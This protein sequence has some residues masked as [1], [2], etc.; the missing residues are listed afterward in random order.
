[1][2]AEVGLDIN[3]KG[4]MKRAPKDFEDE[5]DDDVGPVEEN[6]ESRGR[7]GA[8]TN[9]PTAG[10]KGGMAI[11]QTGAQRKRRSTCKYTNFANTFY[12]QKKE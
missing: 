2:S 6:F 8:K 3:A 9:Q 1:M 11:D 12:S 10:N 4:G 7:A 5:E